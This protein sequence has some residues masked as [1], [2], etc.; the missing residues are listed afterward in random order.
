[1]KLN[2]K[3]REVLYKRNEFLVLGL[4]GS[5]ISSSAVPVFSFIRQRS[6]FHLPS[7]QAIVKRT[8]WTNSKETFIKFKGVEK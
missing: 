7:S 2:G 5:T 6:F 4:P 8:R 3:I 1:M